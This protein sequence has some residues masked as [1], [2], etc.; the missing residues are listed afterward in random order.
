MSSNT[1]TQKMRPLMF[2]G[3]FLLIL[4]FAVSYSA[5][6]D[7]ALIYQNGSQA[8]LYYDTSTGTYADSSIANPNILVRL[9]ADNP[10]DLLGKFVGIYYRTADLNLSATL[11]PANITSVNAS[12]CAVVDVDVS[13]YSAYY[14]GIVSV[15]IG[16]DPSMSGLTFYDLNSSTGLFEGSYEYSY[17]SNSTNMSFSVHAIHSSNGDITNNQSTLLFAIYNGTTLVFNDTIA[18]S[19][20]VTLPL[21]DFDRV[22]YNNMTATLYVPPSPPPGPE[23]EPA[24]EEPVQLNLEISYSGYLGDPAEFYVTAD[25]SPVEDAH[26]VVYDSY[27]LPYD[28]GYTDSSGHLTL[29]I[30]SIGEYYAIA[31]KTDYEDSERVS[32]SVKLRGLII[33]IPDYVYVGDNVTVSVEDD[34]GS[35]SGAEVELYSESGDL[36]DSCYTN[37]EGECTFEGLSDGSYNVVVSAPG[38]TPKSGSFEVYKLPLTVNHPSSVLAGDEFNVRVMSLGEGVSG[39]TVT[40]NDY[41]YRS[42]QEGWIYGISIE[43]PGEYTIFAY[44]EGYSTYKGS[45]KIRMPSMHLKIPENISIY[46]PTTLQVVSSSKECESHVRVIINGTEYESDEDGY[47]E[48]TFEN[49]GDYPVKLVK[50]GCRS[51]NDWLYVPEPPPEFTFEGGFEFNVSGRSMAERIG[52]TLGISYMVKSGCE[53]VN[54]PGIPFIICDLIWIIIL[55]E[56]ILG[57]GLPS[58]PS[59]KLLYLSLPILLS[60][61]FVPMIGA[62]VG[63]L[64]VFLAYRSRMEF[65]SL[66]RSEE[67]Q[68]QEVVGEDLKDEVNEDKQPPGV[69]NISNDQQDNSSESANPDTKSTK[70]E[71]NPPSQDQGNKPN[72]EKEDGGAL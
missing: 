27:D 48:V 3:V 39:A 30:D 20:N 23:P 72:N 56:A 45:I 9:C 66:L 8:T 32:F 6:T 65:Q 19:D 25:G 60:V 28:S 11:Y 34:S 63:A 41:E 67:R 24:P 38:Y 51:E 5:I 58:K 57:Y 54:I 21:T 55:I 42:D 1:K 31:T 12:N 49:P 35:L 46:E 59:H 53:G 17:S 33:N 43:T 71:S 40:L 64:T 15:G 26:I 68:V 14:P 70:D 52:S 7:G 36:I 10:S 62:F 37:S 22:V 18:P 16:N 4:L 29:N 44:K 69:P 61:L 2:R 47:V 50:A 13:I